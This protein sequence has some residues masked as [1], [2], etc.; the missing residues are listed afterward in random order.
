[1]VR[2]I[3]LLTPLLLTACAGRVDYVRPSYLAPTAA[4]VK[5]IE[6]PRDAVWT[7]SVPELGKQY[8]VINNLDKASGLINISY[9]GDPERYIDCGRITSYV[10]N[11]QGERT[12][13]FA[14]AKA[15]Q[16]YEIM[17]PGSGLFFIDRRMNLEGRANL[18]FEEVESTATRVTVNIRYVVN[19]TQTIRKAGNNPPQTGSDT[20]SFNSGGGASFPMNVKGQSLDC[21][22]IGTLE[23]EIL[24][25][26][27]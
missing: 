2:I 16:I 12:H 9:S 17:D 19:R 3:V 4:N 13:E 26:I 10:K 5:I 23:R 15:Q 14:G 21:V 20:V 11:A 18:I 25:F 27:K 1:M 7:S 24:S 22:A 8:F 6:R